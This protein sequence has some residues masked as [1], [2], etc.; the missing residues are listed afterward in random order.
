MPR[1]RQPRFWPGMIFRTPL[2]SIN[3]TQRSFCLFPVQNYADID[4]FSDAIKKVS[5]ASNH[6]LMNQVNRASR[7]S[8]DFILRC[9]R[10]PAGFVL[11]T[12]KS[13]FCGKSP[14]QSYRDGGN[15]LYPTGWEG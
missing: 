11:Q 1:A 5:Q 4:R 8:R 2:S 9:C 7:E 3:R 10:N 6:E 13:A 12:R 14:Q 15:V